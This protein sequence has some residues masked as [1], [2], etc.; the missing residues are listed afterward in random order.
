MEYIA[1]IVAALIDQPT[2]SNAAIARLIDQDERRISRYRRLLAASNVPRS[3]LRQCDSATLGA[4]FNRRKGAWVAPRPD[5]A[6]LLATY[7]GLNGKALWRI[8][9]CDCL[10]RQEEALSY[11]QFSRLLRIER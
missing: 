9:W 2:L 3:T 8:Y 4:Y 7:P 11:E 10:D 6:S 5:F 1:P